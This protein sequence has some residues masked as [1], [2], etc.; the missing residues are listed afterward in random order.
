MV[1]KD[2]KSPQDLRSAGWFANDDLRGFG[3]RSR[4]MQMGYTPEDWRERPIIAMINIWSD[5][6]PCHTHLRE[7]AKWVQRGILQEDSQ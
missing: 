6:N 1:I 5:I 3:H 2:R 7:R 4:A